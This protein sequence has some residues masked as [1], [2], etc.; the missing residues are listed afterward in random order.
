MFIELGHYH[1]L[2]AKIKAI[3]KERWNLIHEKIRKE[4]LL[5]CSPTVGGSTFWIKIPESVDSRILSEKLLEKGVVARSGNVSFFDDSAPSNYI[6]LGYSA[7]DTNRV[8][9]QR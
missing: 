5:S 1:N 4:P 8:N 7:I 9:S 3:N 6:H 2:F